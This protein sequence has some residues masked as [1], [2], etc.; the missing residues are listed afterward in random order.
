MMNMEDFQ[1]KQKNLD[2]TMKG[3]WDKPF[4]DGITD[5]SKYSKAPAKILWILKEPNGKGG[6]NFREFYKDVREYRL[7]KSTYGNI[8]RVSFAIFEGVKDFRDIPQINTNEC[9]IGDDPILDEIA[10]ININKSGGASSTPAGKLGIEYKRDGVKSFLF[11]QIDFI[12]PDIIINCHGVLQ[13]FLDQCV[14]SDIVEINGE[15]FAKSNGRL[16]IFTSH[17]NRAHTE[18]YC[19]NILRIVYQ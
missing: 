10:I 4:L 7:W 5:Y 1:E 8:M 16:I 17:P 9:T 3:I 2:E 13:F 11:D 19:N 18:S 6:G 15:K 12:N 14:D